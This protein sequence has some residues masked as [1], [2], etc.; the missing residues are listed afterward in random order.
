MSSGGGAQPPV[1][2]PVG[3]QPDKTNDDA[4][5][6]Q[7]EKEGRGVQRVPLRGGVWRMAWV[8][9]LLGFG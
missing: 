4:A 8:F 9:L 2:D 6:A 3:E 7:R 5:G 1:L